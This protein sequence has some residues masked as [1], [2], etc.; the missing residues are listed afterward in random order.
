MVAGGS[1]SSRQSRMFGRCWESSSFVDG[2]IQQYR[3]CCCCWAHTELVHCY[4]GIADRQQAHGGAVF[5]F[6]FKLNHY[7]DIILSNIRISLDDS[8]RYQDL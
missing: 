2:S 7:K 5:F 1:E 4:H 6:S 8:I 3:C